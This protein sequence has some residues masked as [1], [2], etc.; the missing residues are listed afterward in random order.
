MLEEKL[1]GNFAV[2]TELDPTKQAS[3][4]TPGGTLVLLPLRQNHTCLRH[5]GTI[6][7][8]PDLRSSQQQDNNYSSLSCLKICLWNGMSLSLFYPLPAL[9]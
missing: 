7:T 3:A 5:L 6:Y 4:K 1:K 9:T 8:T 2:R